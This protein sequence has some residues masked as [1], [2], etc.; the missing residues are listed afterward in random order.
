MAKHGQ[1]LIH[2]GVKGIGPHPNSARGFESP[3]CEP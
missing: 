3:A 2:D 1:P